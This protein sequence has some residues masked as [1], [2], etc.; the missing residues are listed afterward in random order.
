ME[1]ETIETLHFLTQELQNKYKIKDIDLHDIY[2]ILE[3]NRRGNNG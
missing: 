3:N 1:I 2:L